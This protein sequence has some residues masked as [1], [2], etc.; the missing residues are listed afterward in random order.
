MPALRRQL[1]LR[2]TTPVLAASAILGGCSQGSW[3]NQNDELRAR[4]VELE[5]RN[6]ALEAELAEAQLKLS[7]PPVVA[8]GAD[9][10]DPD[11]RAATPRPAMLE[12]DRLSHLTTGDDGSR[13]ARVYVRGY[14]GR[15]RSAVLTGWLDL[16]VVSARA[17]GPETR[18]IGRA[19]L[20]PLD[21]REAYRS[22]FG[23]SRYVVEIPLPP[24]DPSEGG[25]SVLARY[26]D[27]WTGATLAAEGPVGPASP[28]I[29][30]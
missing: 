3:V 15:M 1:R 18:E 27:G 6:A 20:G 9:A 23:A 5:D 28:P 17:G 19:T 10:I 11:V 24:A 25:L 13:I 2:F 22:G 29:D 7:S 26:E 16:R 4:L 14:D 21:V 8:P 12:V 30:R